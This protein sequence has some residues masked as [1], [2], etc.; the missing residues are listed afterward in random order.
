M[1]GNMGDFIS[2]IVIAMLASLV[3]VHLSLWRFHREKLWEKKLEA[4]TAI[5]KSLHHLKI[6]NDKVRM[7]QP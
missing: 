3:T 4:Y 5:I 7:T 6:I 2:H 1:W